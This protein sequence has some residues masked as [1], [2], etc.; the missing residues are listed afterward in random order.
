MIAL[1]GAD[2]ISSIIQTLETNAVE[3]TFFTV[4]DWV[5]KYPEAV[6]SLSEAGMEI[7]NHSLNHASVSKMSYEQNLQDMQ[8]CNE[9][10]EE[11]TGKKVRY[12]RGPSGEYSNA[13]IQAAKACNMMVIQWDADTLDYKRINI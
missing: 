12:Y 2:D 11:V 1:G 3:A 8:K 5:K 13:V 10:I 6:S 7:G 4:G 9:L